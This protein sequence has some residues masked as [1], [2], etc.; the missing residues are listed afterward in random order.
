MKEL[1]IRK[2]IEC[3]MKKYA[4]LLFLFCTSYVLTYAQISEG[5][6]P[7]SFTYPSQLRSAALSTYNLNTSF[8]VKRLIW[9]DEMAGRNGAPL[10]V[11]EALPVDLNIKQTGEWTTLPDGQKIWRQTITADS[12]TALII[13]YRDFYIPEGGK[14]FIYNKDQSHILG[15]YTNKVNPDGGSFAT[16]AIAGDTFTME[17]VASDISDEEPRIELESIGYVYNRESFAGNLPGIN[18]PNAEDGR[19]TCRINVNCPEGANWQKQKRGSV[20]LIFYVPGSRGW[21][22]CSGSLVNNTA[23]DGK[24]YVLTASHCFA[25]GMDHDK[26]IV[27]FNHEFSGCA[28]GTKEPDYKS[29]SKVISRVHVPLSSGSDNY[30][31]EIAEGEIPKEWNPYFNGWDISNNTP[32]S[33]VVLHHPNTDVTK[34]TTYNKPAS[35]TKY[36]GSSPVN[37]YWAVVYDGNSV[38]EKGSSGSPLF[39]EAGLIVGTLTGGSSY[40]DNRYGADVYG[41]LWY[42]WNQYSSEEQLKKYLDPLG[43]GTKILKGYDAGTSGIEEEIWIKKELILFPNPVEN[44]LNINA[45]SIIRSVKVFDIRGRQIFVRNNYNASTI[46]IPAG[47]WSKGVYTVT[48]QTE[49]KT[50]TEKVIKK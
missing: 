40:C 19:T 3:D 5:G 17:Y 22:T 43:K 38:T 42:G 27:Y 23:Q 28:N 48:I 29:M 9:E 13:S 44:E 37:N 26:F 49:D 30:L 41:K 46:Q 45:S 36:E 34:I 2:Q 10:R 35:H 20:L 6:T 11:A 1:D 21:Y 4:L 47:A 16:E 32:Q 31:L 15:A 14:L 12:A 50:I 25:Q 33:G 39:N 24:P 18:T 8:D 7:P